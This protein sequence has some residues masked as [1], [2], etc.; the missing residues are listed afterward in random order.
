MNFWQAVS[1]VF[2]R[3]AEFSGRS[4]RSEYWYFTLFSFIVSTSLA[5]LDRAIFPHYPWSPLQAIYGVAVLLPTLAVGIRRL[6]DIDR[7][8]WWLL[9]WLIPIVGW[10]ILIVWACRKGSDGDN[11]FGPDPL[12]APASGAGVVPPA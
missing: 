8:G 10:I 9:I 1:S 6:H 11:R 5:M 7:S 12:A 4:C 3:Y 2:R